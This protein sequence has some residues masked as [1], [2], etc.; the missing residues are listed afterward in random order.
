MNVT[1]CTCNHPRHMHRGGQSCAA[2]DVSGPPSLA[3]KPVGDGYAHIGRDANPCACESYS[4]PADLSV[5][6]R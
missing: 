3:G 1:R 4:A 2:T 5:V 6:C